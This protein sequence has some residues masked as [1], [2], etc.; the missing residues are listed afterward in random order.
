MLLKGWIF[1]SGCIG[2]ITFL[3]AIAPFGV[4]SGFPCTITFAIALAVLFRKG[5]SY[6]W[7]GK[8]KSILPQEISN[9]GY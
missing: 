6:V 7:P 9:Q 1:K 8:V 4:G 5:K 2:G 3:V